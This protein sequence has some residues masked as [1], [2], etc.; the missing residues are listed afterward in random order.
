MR[1]LKRISLVLV[2]FIICGTIMKADNTSTTQSE[3]TSE[4]LVAS[5]NKDL[6]AATQSNSSE[7]ISSETAN[8]NTSASKDTNQNINSSEIK[9]TTTALKDTVTSSTTNAN[10]NKNTEVNDSSSSSS[11]SSSSESSD[12]SSSSDQSS[13]SDSDD[14][15]MT[16]EKKN[17]YLYWIRFKNSFTF[18]ENQLSKLAR[19]FKPEDENYLQSNIKTGWFMFLIASFFGLLLILYLIGRFIL[20]YF[21]GPKSHISAWYGRTSFIFIFIGFIISMTLFSLSLYNSILAK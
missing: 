10:D 2:I 13:S 14:D 3:T 16:E 18:K 21:K 17:E 5:D 6:T 8:S 4:T 20:G 15:T 1:I 7:N 9:D 12:A 19:A 11:T